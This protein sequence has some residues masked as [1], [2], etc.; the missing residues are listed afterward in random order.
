MASAETKMKERRR[1][2]ET[3]YEKRINESDNENVEA[4]NVKI[5]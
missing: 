4:I 1:K 5:S 2:H 3:K